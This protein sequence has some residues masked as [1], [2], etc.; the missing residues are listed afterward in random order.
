MFWSIFGR[1]QKINFPYNFVARLEQANLAKKK[2][3]I[4]VFVKKETDFDEN[5]INSN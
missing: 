2:N 4:T 3:D 1:T 5:P